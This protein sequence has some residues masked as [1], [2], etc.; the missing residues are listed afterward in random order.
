M[1]EWVAHYA[2]LEDRVSS[3]FDPAA[4]RLFGLAAFVGAWCYLM[5]DFAALEDN[6]GALV[7]V[8]I[9]IYYCLGVGGLSWA[10]W[11]L[12]RERFPWDD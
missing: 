11:H 8:L 1:W 4:R 9:F 6:L 3:A 10:L 7:A 12:F 2:R 5:P